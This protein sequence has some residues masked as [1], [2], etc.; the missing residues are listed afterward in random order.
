MIKILETML[1]KKPII[2]TQDECCI[3]VCKSLNKEIDNT[4]HTIRTHKKHIGTGKWKLE[5][6]L[7][8]LALLREELKYYTRCQCVE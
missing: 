8:T 3:K 7:E 1:A 5:Q 4:A 6:T 2:P